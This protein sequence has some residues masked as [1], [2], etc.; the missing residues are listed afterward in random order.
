MSDTSSTWFRDTPESRRLLEIERAKVEAAEA[1]A[2]ITA[3]LDN[4]QR[5]FASLGQEPSDV[6]AFAATL[7]RGTAWLKV[8]DLRAVLADRKRLADEL[9]EITDLDRS[10]LKHHELKDERSR[11]VRMWHD[12]KK[13][14]DQAEAR[15]VELEAELDGGKVEWT[16]GC[17]DPYDGTYYAGEYTEAGARHHAAQRRGGMHFPAFRRVGAWQRA[18]ATGGEA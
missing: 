8:T 6:I 14:A 12:E 5:Q 17:D 2:E 9:E 7:E 18:E 10:A 1:A 13:R 3:Y 16:I 4:V 11:A 15:V